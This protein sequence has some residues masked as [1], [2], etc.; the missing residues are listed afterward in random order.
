MLRMDPTPDPFD[1]GTETLLRMK[2]RE[3]ADL[4]EL[5]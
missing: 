4:R 2:A 1:Y 3:A 5:L